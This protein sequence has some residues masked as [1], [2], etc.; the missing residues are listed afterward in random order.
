MR[1]AG[2]EIAKLFLAPGAAPGKA[3]IFFVLLAAA[4]HP[5]NLF[6]GPGASVRLYDTFDSEFPRFFNLARALGEFGLVEWYPNI[7]GGLPS[8]AFHFTLLHPLVLLSTELPSWIIYNAMVLAYAWLAGYGMYRLLTAFFRIAH[9]PALL[10]GTLFVFAT[11]FH[12]DSIILNSFRFSF[13]LIFVLL[14]E[15]GR[16]GGGWRRH[17]LAGLALALLCLVSYPILGLV[18]FT[19]LHGAVL[20]LYFQLE[21]RFDWRMV[22]TATVFW[23][24][25]GLVFV[26]NYVA[27]LEFM[28]YVHRTWAEVAFDS[29]GTLGIYL[30]TEFPAVLIVSFLV[31]TGSLAALIYPCFLL[32]LGSRRVRLGC[33]HLLF[34]LFVTAVFY[35]DLYSLLSGTMLQKMDLHYVKW[36]LPVSSVLFVSFALD[37]LQ[38]VSDAARKRFLV[39]LYSF[40]FAVACTWLLVQEFTWN[41][42]KA[43]SLYLL[44]ALFVLFWLRAD[45]PEAW[46]FSFFGEAR[47]LNAVL[48]GVVLVIALYAAQPL[49]REEDVFQRAFG[50]FPALQALYEAHR[51]EP[52]RIAAVG[53]HPSQAQLAGLETFGGRSPVFYRTYKEYASQVLAPQMVDAEARQLYEVWYQILMTGWWDLHRAATIVPTAAS[54][55]DW[56]LKLLALSNVRF[57]VSADPI[58]GLQRSKLKIDSPQAGA[59]PVPLHVYALPDALPRGYLASRSEIL[60]THKAT[61]DRLGQATFEELRHTAFFAEAAAPQ[62][63]AADGATDCGASQIVSYRPDRIVFRVTARAPCYLV[64]SNNFDPLWQATLDEQPVRIY[65]ANHAFQVIAI[66]AEGTH[67]VVLA[68]D[69][70]FFPAIL[71][72]LPVGFALVF[73]SPLAA[74]GRPRRDE[75]GR[76]A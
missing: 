41:D 24:G 9:T 50:H 66:P 8:N 56:N 22:G 26:P 73:L 28:P 44:L 74:A 58:K 17:I 34:F 45:K 15:S 30:V 16:D 43:I 47:L 31:E 67:E 33:F 18:R 49:R 36:L 10:G 53:I 32:A 25:Y 71:G 7:A 12:T 1:R 6:L 69:D 2:Q 54:A 35:S 46:R 13:P 40:A 39:A 70:P 61:L 27:L 29:V 57:V 62:T 48:A 37:R 3:A 4:C 60:P 5:D 63:P 11:Q 64:V 55:A 52:F 21:R 75:A 72:L 14:H 59:S 20:L 42:L 19:I 65:R 38:E 23:A 51:D 68:F 76:H